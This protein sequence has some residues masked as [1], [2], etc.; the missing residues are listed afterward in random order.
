MGFSGASTPA[1]EVLDDGTVVP[2]AS[3]RFLEA[4][5]GVD[6]CWFEIAESERNPAELALQILPEHRRIT[7]EQDMKHPLPDMVG[8][9]VLQRKITHIFYDNTGYQ[10]SEFQIALLLQIFKVSNQCSG[11][12][13][14]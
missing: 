13:S 9:H 14:F 5:E 2:V 8:I 11:I 7:I 3:E 12:L 10:L 4:V 6:G 1:V